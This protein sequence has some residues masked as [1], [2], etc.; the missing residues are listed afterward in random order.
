MFH[1]A[2]RTC[3][4]PHQVLTT[5]KFSNMQFY[6]FKIICF[7]SIPDIS[8]TKVR[9]LEPQLRTTNNATESRFSTPVFC[10]LPVDASRFMFFELKS[11]AQYSRLPGYVFEKHTFN[12]TCIFCNFQNC[13]HNNHISSLYTAVAIFAAPTAQPVLPPQPTGLVT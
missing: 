8:S 1:T 10:S 12:P 11:Q 6:Y 9:C 7:G 3:F 13:T 2:T 5:A 4:N